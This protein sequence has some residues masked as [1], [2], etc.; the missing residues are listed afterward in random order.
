LASHAKV[1]AR[2]RR[3]SESEGGPGAPFPKEFADF[4][5]RENR[6]RMFIEQSD[7]S[8]RFAPQLRESAIGA[9]P[10]AIVRGT[11]SGHR[12]NRSQM[13]LI[14]GH[15]F[16]RSLVA[17]GDECHGVRSMTEVRNLRCTI[18]LGQQVFA[19]LLS[20]PLETFRT[21]D[22]PKLRF[23]LPGSEVDILAHGYRICGD[24][25]RGGSLRLL[26]KGWPADAPPPSAT[27]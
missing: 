17:R 20:I 16:R 21:W 1:Q 25:R 13:S 23:T 15:V 9:F 19:A 27:R 22:S 12:Q 4:S 6:W 7:Q 3:S 11:F 10:S 18:G 14:I 2:A 5:R 24:L 8:R 26:L